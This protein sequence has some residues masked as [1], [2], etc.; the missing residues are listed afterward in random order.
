MNKGILYA[1]GA[2]FIWGFFPIY[3]KAIEQISAFQVTAHRVVWSFLFL[4]LVVAARRELRGLRALIT[5][6]IL[7]IYLAAGALLAVNWLTYVW[8][9]S[10]GFVVEA[11]L[12]YF[13]NPL[14]SVVLGVVFL[15]EKMRPAQWLPVALAACGVTYLTISHGSLPW[16]ALVLAFSFGLYGLMKKL[17]PL[18][19]LHGLVL[20]TGAIFV[21]ALLL[22][23]IS[24]ASGTGA[25][26][27]AGV[28]P[29]LLLALVGVVTAI[30]LLLFATGAKNVPLTT[31][32]LLQYIAP[33][34]QFLIGVLIYGEPFTP[35][36]LVGFGIIWVALVIF[37]TE[38]LMARRRALPT[39]TG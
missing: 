5:R 36:R 21:P 9:V 4:I 17:A 18:G 15:H 11:S 24:E 1:A 25:F 19:S 7:L 32:G 13:I 26:G 14:V 23:V 20:E 16:I 27:H 28:L 6:R 3:F 33:T 35:E 30:P 22:L 37:S 39:T 10:S 31:L 38:N 2:Y 34:I 12:G 29:S 8:A